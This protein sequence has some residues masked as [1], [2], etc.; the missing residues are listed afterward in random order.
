MTERGEIPP[1]ER[2]RLRAAVAAEADVR[3]ELRAAVV[4]AN[5]AGGSVR[6]IATETGKSPTTIQKWIKEKSAAGSDAELSIP[7]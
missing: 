1:P 5:D 4:A 7:D 6:A 3:R 2:D